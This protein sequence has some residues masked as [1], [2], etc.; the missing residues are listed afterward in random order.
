MKRISTLPK[1]RDTLFDG[2]LV[3]RQ[4]L[5]RYPTSDA[6]AV[7]FANVA[8][9][10]TPDDWQ[11]AEMAMVGDQ[12]TA[13]TYAEVTD[14]GLTLRVFNLVTQHGPYLTLLFS[15]GLEG[16]VTTVSAYNLAVRAVARLP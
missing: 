8:A 15:G 7:V 14:D 5:L 12:S 16:E 9:N 2:P 10:G 11:R 3:L 13:W 1:R 6:A 4:Q